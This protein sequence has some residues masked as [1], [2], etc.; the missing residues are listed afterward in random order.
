MSEPNKTECFPML[1]QS[2]AYPWLWGSY[3]HDLVNDFLEGNGSAR[4]VVRDED[5]YFISPYISRLN[6][7]GALSRVAAI[8]GRRLPPGARRM[9]LMVLMVCRR[10]IR[11]RCTR[12]CGTIQFSPAQSLC[13]GKLYPG[14][15]RKGHGC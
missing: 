15:D 13:G 3:E 4:L 10:R 7:R 11:P 1:L 5:S 2:G 12:P 14:L 8:Q 6:G 9:V